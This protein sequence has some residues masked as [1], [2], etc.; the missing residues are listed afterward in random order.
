MRIGQP[1]PDSPLSGCWSGRDVSGIFVAVGPVWRFALIRNGV[2][3]N[4]ETDLAEVGHALERVGGFA[5]GVQDRQQHR[6]QDGD[7]ADDDEQLPIRLKMRAGM[8]RAMG[9]LC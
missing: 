2:L 9:H 6:D 4:R 3:L 8:G 5:D 7:D 1:G